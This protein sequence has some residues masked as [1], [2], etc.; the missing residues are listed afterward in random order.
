MKESLQIILEN[1]I[2]ITSSLTIN[3]VI[4]VLLKLGRKEIIREVTESICEALKVVHMS[5]NVPLEALNLIENFNMK[6]R[7]ALHAAIAKEYRIS[8]IL[9]D[10]G[11]FD[12]VRSMEKYDFK[13]VIEEYKN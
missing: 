1:K 13:R 5:E 12:A 3:E 8:K 10:D 4:R 2:G 7:D 6:P 9:S 11:G